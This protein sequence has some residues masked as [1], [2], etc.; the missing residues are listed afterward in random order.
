MVGAAGQDLARQFHAEDQAT[1]LTACMTTSAVLICLISTSILTRFRFYP[2]LYCVFAMVSASFGVLAV[3]TASRFNGG[4]VLSA[5]AASVVGMAAI[6]GETTTI[7]F[8]KSLPPELIGAWGAGTG[9]AGIFGSLV[10]M[11]LTGPLALS[12]SVVFMLMIPLVV[13]WWAAFHYLHLEATRGREGPQLASARGGRQVRAAPGCGPADSIEP[14]LA[15]SGVAL[16][17][18]TN[19]RA[20]IAASGGIMFNLIAVYF[21]EYLI[22]PGLDDRETLCASK[23]WYMIMWMCYNVGVTASRFSVA[24]F[25]IRRVWVLTAL[26]LINVAGWTLEVFTGAVRDVLPHE[27]GLHFMAAWMVLV[28]LCG[29]ASYS[30][31]MYLFNNQQ[32]IPD[33]LRELGINLGLLMSRAGIALAIVSFGVLDHTIMSKSALLPQGCALGVHRVT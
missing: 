33:S 2:R 9:L 31:C 22:F 15:A 17:T 24:L 16:A 13:P 20:A 19:I 1:L 14:A 18:L 7:A 28:G 4:F 30:N 29:G 26:Q 8:L 5:V 21:L 3:A 32:G 23:Q 11:V 6:M 12:S 25:R 10:Y 27:G